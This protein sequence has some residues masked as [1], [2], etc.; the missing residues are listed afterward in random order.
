MPEKNHV[1]LVAEELEKHGFTAE[2]AD[3][4]AREKHRALVDTLKNG[5]TTAGELAEQIVQ[6]ELGVDAKPEESEPD[7]AAEPEPSKAAVDPLS[8]FESSIPEDR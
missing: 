2:E 5:R 8:A 6:D 7:K 4:L 3:L 1:Q